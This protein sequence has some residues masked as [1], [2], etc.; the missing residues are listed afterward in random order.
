MIT[1]E[2]LIKIMPHAKPRADIWL[3][4]LNDAM[5]EFGIDTQRRV[6]AFLAQVAHESAELRYTREIDSGSAYDTGKL[7]ER[8]GNTPEADG[9]GQRYKGRGL[10]Q[11]TGRPA[12]GHRA[13]PW[14]NSPSRCASTSIDR[15]SHV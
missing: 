11:I 10:I 6:A 15:K 5:S 7:A 14:R 9:D 8:L 13:P 1:R 12:Q 3:Q 4:P 2:Q